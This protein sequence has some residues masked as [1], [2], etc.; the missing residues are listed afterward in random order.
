MKYFQK[1]VNSSTKSH[2]LITVN[3]AS[4]KILCQN[5]F[6]T[7]LSKVPKISNPKSGANEL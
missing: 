2:N 4:P 3:L 5:T 6:F 7:T 1:V